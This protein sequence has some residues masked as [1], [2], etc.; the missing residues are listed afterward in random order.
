MA[1]HATA[2][3]E[4]VNGAHNGS[5]ATLTKCSAVKMKK[6]GNPLWGADVKKRSSMQLQVGCDWQAIEDARA[7]KEG[8]T[9]RKIG[10]LP[11]GEHVDGT[12]LIKHNGHLYMRGFWMKALGKPQ[13]FVD[14]RE[15][16]PEEVETIKQFTPKKELQKTQPINIRLDGLEY[17]RAGGKE[18]T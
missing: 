16:T 18:L 9:P 3:I 15:A 17:L 1:I 6:T 8:R 2:I 11:Y 12:P 5:I 7:K 13:F 4:T 10:P 14:G